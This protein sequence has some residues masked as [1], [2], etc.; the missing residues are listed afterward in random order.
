MCFNSFTLNRES[1][2]WVFSIRS[3]YVLIYPNLTESLGTHGHWRTVHSLFISI[4]PLYSLHT[5]TKR[6]P[7][8]I[9][10]LAYGLLCKLRKRLLREGANSS[11]SNRPYP[12]TIQSSRPVT[13]S[14]TLVIDPHILLLSLVQ[15]SSTKLQIKWKSAKLCTRRLAPS[16]RCSS[17]SW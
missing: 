17:V 13:S 9:S 16:R 3:Y 12:Q 11:P 15:P 7:I 2:V 1:V 6:R 8:T 5:G 14:D 10:L 4:W